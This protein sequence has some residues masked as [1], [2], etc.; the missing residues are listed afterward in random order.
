MKLASLFISS[1]LGICLL[2]VGCSTVPKATGVTVTVT[3]IRPVDDSS[4]VATRAIMT[5]RFSSENVNALGFTSTSHSLFLNGR[6]VGK[7]ENTSPIGLT[8]QGS[9]TQDVTLQLEKPEIVRQLLS[10]SD[11][12]HYR[13]ESVLFYT[14]DDAKV[15]VKTAAD[16]KIDLHGLEPAAR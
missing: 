12:A 11:D 13:L 2:A 9:A 7:A 15:R 3:S 16:G 14:D 6:Y 4:P 10:V 8:P 5:L 1:L